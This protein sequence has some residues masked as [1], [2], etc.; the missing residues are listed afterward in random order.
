MAGGQGGFFGEKRSAAEYRKI[1]AE[2]F[3]ETEKL[4]DEERDFWGESPVV[5]DQERDVY[6]FRDDGV[7]AFGPAT[8]NE[9]ALIR[10]GLW[11]G[12]TSW[13]AARGCRG[14]S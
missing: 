3:Y 14:T 12:P 8:I 10:R 2:T 7:F 9:W 1:A 11:E 4:M 5:Y 13:E 6:R